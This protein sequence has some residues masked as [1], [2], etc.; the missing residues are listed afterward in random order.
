MSKQVLNWRYLKT[1]IFKQ[2]AYNWFYNY[3]EKFYK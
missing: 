1:I 3:V 2:F